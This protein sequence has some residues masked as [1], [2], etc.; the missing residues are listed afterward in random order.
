[1]MARM[2]SSEDAKAMRIATASSIPG[3]QS[4]MTR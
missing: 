2:S 3:S 4:M 1:V